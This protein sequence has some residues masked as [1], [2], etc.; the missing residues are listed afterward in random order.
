M[1]MRY[2]TG[3]ELRLLNPG[4]NRLSALLSSF[5]L[6]R[7]VHLALHDHGA[8]QDAFPVCNI[9]SSQS[10]QVAAAQLA[11]DGEVEED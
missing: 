4:S 11:I 2:F 5:K 8:R 10:D 3:A 9:A 1:T 6:H 7:P